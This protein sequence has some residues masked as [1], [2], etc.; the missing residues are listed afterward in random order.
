MFQLFVLTWL[1]CSF[2]QVTY[3]CITFT[4]C[5]KCNFWDTLPLFSTINWLDHIWVSV[6]NIKIFSIYSKQCFGQMSWPPLLINLNRWW[7]CRTIPLMY[8]IF[9]FLRCS[10]VKNIIES[11]Y[12]S[13][14]KVIHELHV[15]G[16]LDALVL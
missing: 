16:F 7:L 4:R 13:A 3:V 14:L 11:A 12:V 9:I 10:R 6:F 2:C 5:Y 1:R 8:L 15:L